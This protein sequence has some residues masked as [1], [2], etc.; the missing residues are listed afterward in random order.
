MVDPPLRINE[1]EFQLENLWTVLIEYFMGER[2]GGLFVL[3]HNA[4]RRI[5]CKEF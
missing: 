5:D 3:V 2:G 4:L 1:S